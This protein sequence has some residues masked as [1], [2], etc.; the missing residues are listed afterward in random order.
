MELEPQQDAAIIVEIAINWSNENW[1]D[2]TAPPTYDSVSVANPDDF[3]VRETVHIG[4]VDI[5]FQID[6]IGQPIRI[7]DYNPLWVSYDVR[8]LDYSGT[9]PFMGGNIHLWH[10][11]VPEPATMSL[12][13]LG[14]LAVLRRRRKR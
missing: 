5:G 14:G 1:V 9:E 7:P 13:A 10:E 11:H 3:I 2:A 6:N 4:P 8:I 12:L